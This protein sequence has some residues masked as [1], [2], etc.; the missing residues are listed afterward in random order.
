AKPYLDGSSIFIDGRSIDAK[1]IDTIR[2]FQTD[3]TSKQL[4]V[5]HE[6]KIEQARVKPNSSGVIGVPF[7][8]LPLRLSIHRYG[9]DVTNTFIT[10]PM[11][12]KSKVIHQDQ[13]SPENLPDPHSV[14]VVHGRDEN[15]R[16][17]LFAFLRAI[18]LKPIEW[19]QAVRLTGQGSPYIG[20]VLDVAFSKAQAAVILMTPDD[21]ARLHQR[22]WKPD[23]H[24]NE[25][26]L[27]PQARP[28]VLFE[29]G[30][31]FGKFPERTILVEL[32]VLRSFSDIA[33]RHVI[34]FDASS[35]KRLEL[36][37]RLDTAGCK[38]D[39]TGQDWLSEGDFQS[40][41][42]G[43]S[44]DTSGKAPVTPDS[45]E[46]K[47]QEVNDVLVKVL[48]LAASFDRL[49]DGYS[50][51]KLQWEDIE[52]QRMALIQLKASLPY[53]LEYQNVRQSIDQFADAAA[54]AFHI[55]P[56]RNKQLEQALENM[57]TRYTNL[58]ATIKGVMGPNLMS[59]I[60][61]FL[62]HI[63]QE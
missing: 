44:K 46:A 27:T 59:G 32:G 34:R 35:Q 47:A 13:N 33:G 57:T 4:A 17:A 50:F 20:A 38:L 8:P 60:D 31:A 61:W 12:S 29:A 11:G 14:M 40:A 16:K 7:A 48:N 36:A 42:V 6:Q 55:P 23:D 1:N 30:M 39:L 56:K 2:I 24:S 37:Q 19:S 3:V 45:A 54:T 21:E 22:F 51:G 62:Q 49:A 25:N 63:K 43:V 53:T 15:A 28:N 18:G 58:V 9:H 26:E 5:V 52:P 10:R 41:M